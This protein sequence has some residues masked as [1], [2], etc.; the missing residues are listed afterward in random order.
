LSVIGRTAA[1]FFSKG[2]AERFW[3]PESGAHCDFIDAPC[4]LREKP[5]RPEQAKFLNHVVRPD[6]KYTA[7]DL[8]KIG[9][10]HSGQAGQALDTK[11]TVGVMFGDDTGDGF[12]FAAHALSYDKKTSK[13]NSQQTGGTARLL[14]L[15]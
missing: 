6:A 4:G 12:G 13:G 3:A 15:G 9:C 8:A 11:I 5:C 1:E 14:P 2:A 7:R 10:A